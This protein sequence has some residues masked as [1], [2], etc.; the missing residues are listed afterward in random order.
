MRRVGQAGRGTLWVRRIGN[1]PVSACHRGT[2]CCTRVASSS[3]GGP[4]GIQF[5]CEPPHAIPRVGRVSGRFAAAPQP[6]RSIPRSQ[7]RS[8]AARDAQRLRFRA[9][10]LRQDHAP[11]LRLHVL[12]RRRGVHHAPQP[13]GLRLGRPGSARPRRRGPGPD[14]V[15]LSRHEPG[16][17]HNDFAHRP[18]CV[19][20]PRR[21]GG[22]ARGRH[23][24]IQHSVHREQCGHLA[25]GKDCGR[26]HRPLVVPTL[27]A[28]GLRL[29]PP[30]AR[31]GASRRLPGDCRHGGPAGFRLRASDA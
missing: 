18:P 11:G 5:R 13:G 7:P 9:G 19:V 15:D 17:S 3:I 27:P 4:L 28:A 29:Q 24:R 12:G 21:R 10:C 8:G 26:G 22:H 25:R 14:R 16:L 1:P 31:Q 20:Q 30:D 23:G 2:K 6:A